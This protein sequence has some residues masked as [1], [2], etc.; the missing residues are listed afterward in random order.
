VL[1]EEAPAPPDDPDA[2]VFAVCVDVLDASPGNCVGI[3]G[4]IDAVPFDVPTDP[5]PE[6]LPCDDGK[7]DVGTLNGSDAA[8]PPLLAVLVWACAIEK[9]RRTT[10]RAK[11]EVRCIVLS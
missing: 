4:S 8:P 1:E 3:S 11:V 6:A 7:A 2:V 5:P 9:P 10:A